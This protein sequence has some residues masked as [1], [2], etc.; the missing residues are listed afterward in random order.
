MGDDIMNKVVSRRLK[1]F[2]V[3]MT[4]LHKLINLEGQTDGLLFK[5]N[6]DLIHLEKDGIS[7][8]DNEILRS[9]LVAAEVGSGNR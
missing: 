3:E 9:N 1:Q 5:E 8:V 2:E 4:S 7:Q 6:G